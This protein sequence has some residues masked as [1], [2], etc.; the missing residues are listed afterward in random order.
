MST[1]SKILSTQLF[2]FVVTAISFGRSGR[3][4]IAIVVSF[5]HAWRC[6]GGHKLTEVPSSLLLDIFEDDDGENGAT[7]T[8]PPDFAVHSTWSKISTMFDEPFP[9]SLR[10]LHQTLKYS[11]PSHY[12]LRFQTLF[13]SS[14]AKTLVMDSYPPNT[15]LY[16]R[17]NR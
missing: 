15:L 3:N 6:A 2:C 14:Y 8:A 7:G 16:S 1:P 13:Y 10:Q 12:C 17:P 11:S 9:P 4:A 5:A